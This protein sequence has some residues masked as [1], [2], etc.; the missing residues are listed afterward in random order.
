MLTISCHISSDISTNGPNAAT[1]ALAMNTSTRPNSPSAAS[2]NLRMSLDDRVSASSAMHGRPSSFTIAAVSSSWSRCPSARP[3]G[4]GGRCRRSRFARLRV[5]TPTRDCALTLR[6]AGDHHDLVVEP[7][8]S[9]PPVAVGAWSSSPRSYRVERRQAVGDV[10]DRAGH[11]GARSAQHEDRRVDD[12]LDRNPCLA[13]G[14][15]RFEGSDPSAAASPPPYSRAKSGDA[16][17]TPSIAP[18]QITLTATPVVRRLE[19]DRLRQPIADQPAAATWETPA[20]PRRDSSPTSTS[21]RPRPRSVSPGKVSGRRCRRRAGWCR[22]LRPIRRRTCVPLRRGRRPSSRHDE[23]DRAE[24]PLDRLDGCGDVG[25]GTH[26]GRHPDRVAP[27]LL[28]RSTAASSSS[29]PETS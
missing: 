19:R 8:H 7:T 27:V 18:E 16:L 21:I 25:S 14:M 17:G 29:V 2:T 23:G 4:S 9:V 13:V 12:G 26:V 1:P 15:L 28:R 20:T 22:R 24:L 6:A 5:R 11:R 10:E 3:R